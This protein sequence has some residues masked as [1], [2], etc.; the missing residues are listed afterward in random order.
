MKKSVKIII[1]IILLLLIS[2]IFFLSYKIYSTLHGYKEAEDMY[3]NISLDY[4][5]DNTTDAGTQQNTAGSQQQAE[6]FPIDVDFDA[7]MSQCPNVCGWLYSE[8][9]V[10]NYPL[11]QTYDNAYYLTRLPD[12]TPNA[13]GSLFLDWQC[14]KDFSGRSTVIYG[15]HMNDGSMLASICEYKNQSY[16]DAH[17]YMYLST[18]TRN[19]K[20]EIFSGFITSSDSSAYTLTFGTDDLYLAFILKMKSF[21]DFTNDVQLSASDRVICLSTCTY[22]YNDARYVV[23]GK[24]VPVN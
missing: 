4:V 8:N 2:V 24:L 3:N 17:P 19:Y 13:N 23:F 7:L 6:A 21:S 11:V 10:I 14:Y 16:Y 22:E 12:G 5:T 20:V 18:P 15:H 9:T 1:T